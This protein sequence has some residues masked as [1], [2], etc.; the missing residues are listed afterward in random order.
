MCQCPFNNQI[1]HAFCHLMLL[2]HLKLQFVTAGLCGVKSPYII[3]SSLCNLCKGFVSHF[4]HICIYFMKFCPSILLFC[5]SCY[6]YL[7]LCHELC[8]SSFYSYYYNLVTFGLILLE[9]LIFV[10]IFLQS[11]SLRKVEV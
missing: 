1:A 2:R 11:S 7:Y 3:R 9:K 5:I 10:C 8:P 6:V 4:M